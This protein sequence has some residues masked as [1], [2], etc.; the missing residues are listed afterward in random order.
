MNEEQYIK[1][2]CEQSPENILLLL[3]EPG[4]G[5]SSLCMKKVSDFYKREFCSNKIKKVFSFSL[6]PT[7]W[8]KESENSLDIKNI[9][10]LKNEE[11]MYNGKYQNIR[12]GKEYL[13]ESLIFLDGYDEL[14]LKLQE[15]SKSTILF[16]EDLKNLAE[17]WNLK[18]VIT[19][20][21]TCINP[22]E[23]YEDGYKIC[24][25]AKLTKKEQR[26]WINDVYNK[27]LF[28]E[29]PYDI[30]RIY[31]SSFQENNMQSKFLELLEIPIL[32]QLIVSKYVY[33]DAQNIVEL[34]DKLFKKILN[35]RKEMT[36][37]SYDENRTEEFKQIFESYAYNIYK[38][39]DTYTI[40]KSEELKE[41]ENTKWKSLLL[42]YVKSERSTQPR[43]YYVEFIHRSFYQYF[44]AWYFYNLVLEIIKEKKQKRKKEKIDNLFEA[45]HW[46]EI[47]RDVIDMIGQISKNQKDIQEQEQIKCILETF[48]KLNGIVKKEINKKW[49]IPIRKLNNLDK[50]EIIRYNLLMILNIIISKGLIISKYRKIKTLI[51]KF[52]MNEIYLP[53]IV[54]SGLKLPR[55]NL[56]NAS[57][58][59]ANLKNAS[60]KEA[61]LE[62]AHLEN[63]H[64]E[65][66]HLEGAH[67]KGAHL[68][69]AYLE[70]AHLTGAHLKWTHLENAHLE[71]TNLKNAYLGETNLTGAHL[72]NTD[73]TGADL[74]GADLTIANLTG[75][76]LEN[77]HLE[78]VHLEGAYLRW[79]HLENAHLENA[80]LEGARLENAHLE[81]A[82]LEGAHLEGAY[83]TEAHLENAHLEGAHLTRAYLKE[84]YLIE[85]HLERAH[86]K[87][88]Y[89][90]GAYLE[91]AYFDPDILK[92]TIFKKYKNFKK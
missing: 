85:A 92:N 19:S 22:S 20:R 81:G 31:S 68:E 12:L 4:H 8:I 38:N 46:K 32:L 5:K 88:A 42:F 39:N 2:W 74:T 47:E 67:L 35:T 78:E 90:E 61:D 91:G 71:E 58:K 17:S 54:L 40:I 36:I 80:H 53:K 83:L 1:N 16:L 43:E 60:L 72:E 64:L 33:D 79:T 69:G 55:V 86:F 26:K 23:L 9:F 84:A 57:L 44:Q 50:V 15:S 25:L 76:H 70:G 89:L 87:G 51:K 62:N 10:T 24:Q 48:G 13:K 75:A 77:A 52:D 73:L 56:K 11:F 7:A 66:A 65:G 14:Y 28:P 29:N 3:G 18:I 82:Y 63:A 41:K 59:E 21:K 27:E 49:S 34:Y 37:D 6:N 45:I 30:E